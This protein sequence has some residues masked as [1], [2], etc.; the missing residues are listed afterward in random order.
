MTNYYAVLG[1]RPD[2]SFDEIRSAYRQAARQ[3]HPD[4]DGNAEHFR[5]L[6]AAYEALRDPPTRQHYDDARRSWMRQMGAICCTTCGH[7]N[8]ITRRP[9]EREV[10]RC[11]HCKTPLQ[12]A[13]GDLLQAQRQSLV[14]E[15]TRFVEEVGIDLADLATDAVR[16]GIAR[17]RQRIGLTP[18]QRLKP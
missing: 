2:A 10:V 8:R 5:K 17:L 6:Q 9:T 12:L 4:L 15:T 1:V 7:A 3:A 13:R 18:K 16:A 11:W 14:H